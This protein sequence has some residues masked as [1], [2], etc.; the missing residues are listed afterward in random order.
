[1]GEYVRLEVGGLSKLFVASIEG[2]HIRSVSCVDSHMGTEVE[3]KGET[4]P[5]SF[6][7]TL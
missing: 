2:A 6:K 1:M 5:T 7:C 3:V 4:L